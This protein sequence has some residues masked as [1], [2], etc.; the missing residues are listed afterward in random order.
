M[1]LRKRRI[2]ILWKLGQVMKPS[3]YR[4]NVSRIL[5]KRQLPTIASV[6]HAG[7]LVS[8]EQRRGQINALKADEAELIERSQAVA[9]SAKQFDDFQITRPYLSSHLPKASN[10]L[11]DFLLI[12]FK[13]G[14]GG[15]PG[16]LFPGAFFV[17]QSPA[18]PI[19]QPSMSWPV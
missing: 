8:R 16:F 13:S 19:S 5:P 12:R 2:Q 3:V 10:K 7:T 17:D 14:V 9:S 1:Y 4:H 18:P 6:T 15:F 11:S